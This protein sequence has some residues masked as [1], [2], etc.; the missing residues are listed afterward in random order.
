MISDTKK[1]Q[2]SV[3]LMLK[4]CDNEDKETQEMY[5][6]HATQR[7]AQILWP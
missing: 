2:A 6:V 1:L 3:A 5:A 4:Q 7:M